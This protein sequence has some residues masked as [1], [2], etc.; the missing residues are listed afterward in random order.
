MCD[1][2]MKLQT[3]LI[4][5][6][7]RLR[8]K[9]LVPLIQRKQ[10]NVIGWSLRSSIRHDTNGLKKGIRIRKVNNTG[11]LDENWGETFPLNS[12]D[13]TNSDMQVSSGLL[14]DKYPVE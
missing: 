6:K 9:K 2:D 5:A 12:D 11:N 10:Q 13:I 8:I 1:V 14:R 4:G 3:N 7:G